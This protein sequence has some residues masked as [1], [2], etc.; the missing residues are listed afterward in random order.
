MQ[1]RLQ[2]CVLQAK[3]YVGPLLSVLLVAI[4]AFARLPPWPFEGT[5]TMWAFSPARCSSPPPQ[6]S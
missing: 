1:N 5:A 4:P 3:R 6:F 2:P